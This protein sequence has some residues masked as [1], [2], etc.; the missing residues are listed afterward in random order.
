[1]D[2]KGPVIPGGEQS[3]S[4]GMTTIFRSNHLAH[5]ADAPR[6]HAHDVHGEVRHLVD[7]EAKGALI[8]HRELAVFL[9][10]RGRGA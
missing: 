6:Q 2:V 9:D 4:A 10:A 7:H 3:G 1:M 8:D 5:A